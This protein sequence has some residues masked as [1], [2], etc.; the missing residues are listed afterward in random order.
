MT[1]LK[2][3]LI[4]T[5]WNCEGE[6]FDFLF[7]DT[8]L[9]QRFCFFVVYFFDFVEEVFIRRLLILLLIVFSDDVFAVIIHSLKYLILQIVAI[10][11]LIHFL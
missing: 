10:Q 9:Y 8:I 7:L 2:S 3:L 1:F 11:T 4:L 6:S 5:T